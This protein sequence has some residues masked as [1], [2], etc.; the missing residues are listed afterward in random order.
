MKMRHKIAAVLLAL[1]SLIIPVKEVGA[2]GPGNPIDLGWFNSKYGPI[3]VVVDYNNHVSVE[4]CNNFQCSNGLKTVINAW[5]PLGCNQLTVDS[6]T[7]GVRGARVT[8]SDPNPH[9]SLGCNA[10]ALNSTT[11]GWVTEEVVPVVAG[12]GQYYC[13][14][15]NRKYAGQR[16]VLPGPTWKNFAPTSSG[17]SGQNCDDMR[18]EATID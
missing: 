15:F 13:I 12:S 6:G 8:F 14:T 11:Q 18:A 7:P 2:V 9:S 16:L 17:W 1:G 5:V 4:Y 10:G 3:H